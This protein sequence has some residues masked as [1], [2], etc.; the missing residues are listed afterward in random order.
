MSDSETPRT[1]AFTKGS[2]YDPVGSAIQ[3]MQELERENARLQADAARL[4]KLERLLWNGEQDCVILFPFQSS[5]DASVKGID[6]ETSDDPCSGSQISEG[7]TLRE[8]ID[9]LPNAEKEEDAGS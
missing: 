9:A 5:L 1:D 4:D 8:A 6:I 7:K 3:L 2:S